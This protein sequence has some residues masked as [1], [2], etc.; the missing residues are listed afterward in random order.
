MRDVLDGTTRLDGTAR[1]DG[2][3]GAGGTAASFAAAAAAAAAS[4]ASS[5]ADEKCGSASNDDKVMSAAEAVR[6]FVLPG[7]IVGMG[8][9]NINR[10]PMAL[11]HEIVRQGVGG[12][13][14]M[15]CNLSLPADI[16]VAAGLVVRTEQGSGNLERYG[17][18]F[19]WRRAVER[20]E[21]V[22]EDHSHLT[23]VTRFL[24]GSLG[25]P[26]IPT[27]SL[28]GSDMAPPADGTPRG[29]MAA[30]V[31]PWAGQ[32]VVL[33]R[34]AR[35]DVSLLHVHAAD[36]RGNVIIEGVTSHEIEM[37]KASAVTI[38][39]CE[40]LVEDHEVSRRPEQVSLPSAYVGAVVVQ[41]F[42]AFPTSVY[43]RY[44]FSEDDIVEYQSVARAGDADVRRWLD[45]HVRAVADFDGFLARRDPAGTVRAELVS[46]METIT[47]ETITMET[48]L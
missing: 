26:F 22:V 1:L 13:V 9:Q 27:L 14:L 39:T 38:V 18:L 30:A 11:V 15:G 7:S 45:E 41:P 47:M 3:R 33:L 42:G 24:A 35:P 8:G 28:L 5:G 44:D 4:A 20:G 21:I 43:R 17:T 23:M 12:L 19:A 16:L 36:A 34:K 10:C 48:M 31:D 37:A 40:E 32:P 25:L 46:T 6:R 29:S 2:T